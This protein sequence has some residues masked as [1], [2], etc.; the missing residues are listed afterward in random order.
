MQANT[1]ITIPYEGEIL[2]YDLDNILYCSSKA[3]YCVIHT[4]DGLT[5]TISKNLKYVEDNLP[6]EIFHRVHHS[7]LVNMNK[8]EKITNKAD[9]TIVLINGTTLPLARRRKSDF[10][11]QFINL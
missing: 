2:L 10:L 1:K 11:K 9:T 5:I 6:K 8:I 7:V 3:S 4:T